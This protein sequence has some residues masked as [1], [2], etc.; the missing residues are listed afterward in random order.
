[1]SGP[2]V[3][4]DKAPL[5]S[6]LGHNFSKVRV[7]GA[8]AG[9]LQAKLA[10]GEPNDQYEQE[11]DRVAGE[12]MRMPN[13]GIQPGLVGERVSRL[14]NQVVPRAPLQERGGEGDEASTGEPQVA[15]PDALPANE[16]EQI[17]LGAGSMDVTR[18]D[19]FQIQT[20]RGS[21]EE[22]PAADRGF[23]ESR[24]GQ[25]FDHVRIHT[26][27]RSG[28]LARNLGARAFTLG[29][30]IVFGESEYKPATA[31]G[32]HLLAHE[33]THV[34]Q[35][36]PSLSRSPASPVGEPRVQRSLVGPPERIGTTDATPATFGTCREFNWVVN[37]NTDVRDGFILQECMNADT[38]TKCDG[39]NVPAPNTPHYWE[40][41]P[42]DA[43]GAV[44]DGGTDTWFRARRAGT[45]GNWLFDSNV[46]AAHQLDP[47]WGFGRGNVAT[48]G[49]LLSTTTG[50]NKDTELYMPSMT[51]HKAGEWNCCDGN[52]Y[53]R[54]R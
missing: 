38:I 25:P 34:L 2:E 6:R 30:D 5:E 53:N 15:A 17:D 26:D 33:L 27:A 40:A 7:Q 14:S 21:G 23:M 37:W 36:Q 35:Q 4:S 47:A 19:E 48:A 22:L 11:A 41:W 24:F 39:T 51:R 46:F 28:Q 9:I 20:M 29:Q 49:G 52:N 50:P 45:R 42:V 12:I 44:G 54:A 16:D 31:D 10:V 13:A 43:A 18:Q 8:G 3:Q 1:M 32:R